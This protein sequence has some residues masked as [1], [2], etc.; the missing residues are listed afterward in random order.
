MR[1]R[2]LNSLSSVTVLLFIGL[3]FANRFKRFHDK[4]SDLLVTLSEALGLYVLYGDFWCALASLP[5]STGG[6]VPVRTD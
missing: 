5:L 1:I 4:H 3:M 6:V 2:S